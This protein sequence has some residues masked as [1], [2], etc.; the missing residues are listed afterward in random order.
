[1]AEILLCCNNGE[2][3]LGF[4]DNKVLLNF[5]AQY[6]KFV[7]IDEEMTGTIPLSE[8]I[9][10]TTKKQMNILLLLPGFIIAFIIVF[11]YERKIRRTEPK[12]KVH[13]YVARD[14]DNTLYLYMSKPIRY[15]S[16]FCADINGQLIA[17]ELNF[18][19]FNLKVDYI[20]LIYNEQ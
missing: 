9:K 5:I 8:I 2:K 15:N 4:T 14:K 1:M 6:V 10:K 3:L 16:Y 17:S 7:Q 19:A 18:E 12:N 13:F 20:N 11:Y